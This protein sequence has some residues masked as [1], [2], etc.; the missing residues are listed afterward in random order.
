[1]YV[2]MYVHVSG[3]EPVRIVNPGRELGS[4]NA[5][6]DFFEDESESRD[7]CSNNRDKQSLNRRV[8]GQ[9]HAVIEFAAARTEGAGVVKLRGAT[10]V[11]DSLSATCK[12]PRAGRFA[13][14]LARFSQS[15]YLSFR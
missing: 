5:K 1:M 2:C 10:T 11:T 8:K 4:R 7:V 9:S 12:E 3:P 15:R 13:Y 6:G 14:F